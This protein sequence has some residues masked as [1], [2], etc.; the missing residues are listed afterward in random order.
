MPIPM[1]AMRIEADSHPL[2]LP[3]AALGHK[4]SLCCSL[5]SYDKVVRYP[6]QKKAMTRPL[7]AELEGSIS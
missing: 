1:A 3:I 5:N 2:R 4:S 7:K 6:G